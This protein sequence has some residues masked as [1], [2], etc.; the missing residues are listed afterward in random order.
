MG[1]DN[2]SFFFLRIA[3]NVLATSLS[4]LYN[5]SFQLGIFPN[6]LKIAKVLPIYESGEKAEIGNYRPN[7]V[8]SDISKLL[9][10][11]IFSRTTGFF[12]KHSIISKTQYRFRA[13]HSTTHALLDVITSCFNNIN[14]N[15]YTA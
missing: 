5:C 15:Y 13:N 3:A 10:K 9:E 7:F 14:D 6:S 11:L 1:Y 2:I 4:Y 8:L 12:E